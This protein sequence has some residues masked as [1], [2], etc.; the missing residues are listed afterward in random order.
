[1]DVSEL[2]A[3]EISELI[4]KQI[5]DFEKRVDVSE[6]GTV[7]KVGDGIAKIYGLDKCMASE[8]LDAQARSC[9]CLSEKASSGE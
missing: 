9:Q 2:K 6:V 4:K 7:V 8:L 3:D 5:A 1:M